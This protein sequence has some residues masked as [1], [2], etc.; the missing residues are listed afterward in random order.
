MA[1]IFALKGR[2]ADNP[3]IVHIADISWI[4]R[5]AVERV[6]KR[7]R[8]DKDLHAWTYNRNFEEVKSGARR[9]DGRA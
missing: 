4:D 2:P 5:L 7:E 6:E 3:L 1:H 8:G 9:S